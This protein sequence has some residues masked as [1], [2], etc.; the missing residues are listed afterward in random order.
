MHIWTG[1][2]AAYATNGQIFANWHAGKIV[3]D[4]RL[5]TT[6]DIF[7]ALPGKNSDGHDFIAKA[8]DNGAHVAIVSHIPEYLKDKTKILLV[9]D[10]QKALYDLALYKRKKSK[11]KFIAVTGSVGKTSV[12]E[13]LYLALSPHGISFAS[14]GNYNNYLGVPINLAS[15]PNDAE[16]AVFEIGMDHAGEITNLSKLVAPDIAL[17]NNIEHIH[18]A[19]F[20]SMEAIAEAKSEIFH[21]ISPNGTAIINSLSNCYELLKSMTNHIKNIIS[22]GIE[23]SIL[24]YKIDNNR[25]LAQLDI[26]GEKIVIEIARIISRAQ[27]NNMVMALSCIKSMGLD[28]T[29]S[30]KNIEK[31]TPPRG[32]GLVSLVKIEENKTITLIDDSYNSGPVSLRAALENMTAYNGRKVVILGD[33]TEMGDD[34]INIHKSLK[35][36]IIKN[37][38]DKVICFGEHMNYLYKTL[39]LEKRMG[40]Y[41]HLKDLA[42]ALPDKLANGDILLIK[43]SYYLTNLYKFTEHL[44]QGDLSSLCKEAI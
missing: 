6:G 7:L 30:A 32:R 20:A 1:K 42:K 31:F 40:S 16:Y 18:R 8:F 33:M 17:I 23:S 21:G 12:K 13:L 44:I 3:F 35:E 29:L 36:D 15:I 10:V 2:E 9:K 27:I 4:S 24:E 28:I 43:G 34:S 25:T 14:R 41:F 37:N 26:M 38:I 19:N 39:P 5:I 22:V 11:A